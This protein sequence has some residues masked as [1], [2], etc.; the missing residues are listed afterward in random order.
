M[1]KLA[2]FSTI[3]DNPA[4]HLLKSPKSPRLFCACKRKRGAG[5]LFVV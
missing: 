1:L 4:L 5:F 2:L 3:E